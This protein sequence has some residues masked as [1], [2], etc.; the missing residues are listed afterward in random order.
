MAACLPSLASFPLVLVISF[1]RRA[2]EIGC[3]IYKGRVHESD[4]KWTFL[5]LVERHFSDLLWLGTVALQF[6]FVSVTH[7]LS[8]FG[9]DDS[10]ALL[11]HG[12]PGSHW[13]VWSHHTLRT[14]GD[15]SAKSSQVPEE[16]T[17]AAYSGGMSPSRARCC[18]TYCLNL[19]CFITASW[20]HDLLNS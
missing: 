20:K 1:L 8:G 9:S 12:P 15:R 2:K 6:W 19:L 17:P 10:S 4:Q 3:R 5:K 16:G 7:W 14:V 18:G 11:L 13:M